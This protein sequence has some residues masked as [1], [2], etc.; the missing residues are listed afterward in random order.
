MS[1]FTIIACLS[2]CLALTSEVDVDAAASVYHGMTS[3]CEVCDSV[4]DMYVH[5]AEHSSGA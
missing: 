4:E 2:I 5:T 3:H 1:V